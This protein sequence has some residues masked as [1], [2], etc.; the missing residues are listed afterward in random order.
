MGQ[1]Q[2]RR[3]QLDRRSVLLGAAAAGGA[4]LLPATV[5][6]AAPAPR[7]GGT[8][9]VSMPYNPASL[10]PITGRNNPDYNSLFTLY[11]ALIDF[12]P[13]TL[14]L[15]PALARQWRFTDPRTL[16]LDLV[17]GVE[18]HDGTP[19]NPEAV[20]FNLDR[21]RSDKRSNVKPDLASLASVEVTGK[22]QVTLHLNKPNAG[23]PAILSVRAGL[24]VSPTSV[25]Q[26]GPNVDR[27][28]VGTGPFTFVGW[29]DNEKITV[30]RN[31]HY[32][33]SGLPYLD[34]IEF[35]IINE[36]NTA[37]RTV[38]AG[39]ADLALNMGVPQKLTADRLKRLV[40]TASPSLI[41][42]GAHLNYAKGPL[43]DVRV[44]QAMNYGIDR[45]EINKV[46]M[47]GLGMPSSC[48]TP[49]NFWATDPSTFN[50]YN[51]DPE[52]AKKLLADAGHANG[53]TLTS[54]GWP[55]Q[56]SMQRQELLV[57]QL[58]KVGIHIKLTPRSPVQVATE[59]YIKKHGD[60]YIAPSGGYPDP[61]LFYASMYAKDAFLNVASMELPGFRPLLDATMSAQDRTARKAAVAKLQRFTIEQAMELPQYI[62]PGIVIATPKVK[63]FVF[64]LVEA[65]KLAEVWLAA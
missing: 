65:P 18:F 14:E 49:K 35:G 61:S 2:D 3:P 6:A 56:T 55:D 12:E 13:D 62:M 10:D 29:Q 41:F 26:H 33:R 48:M 50:Y 60:M 21:G 37:A 40:T 8:L 1:F 52:R 25:K 63:N 7:K 24:M 31:P 44:R 28:P 59:F 54:W 19:F 64:G 39:Q 42:M 38:I 30:K 23:L 53:L 43:T 58:A 17:E 32:W 27:T 4:M 15:K 57:S 11:D 46:V 51:Y 22:N 47:A 5:K 34:G 9:R 36:L 16:V 45:N 20:K